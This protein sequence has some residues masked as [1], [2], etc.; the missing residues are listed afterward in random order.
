MSVASK[1]QKTGPI[2]RQKMLWEGPE[3]TGKNG[4]VTQG[5][6]ASFLRCRERARIYCVEGLKRREDFSHRLEFGSMFHAAEEYYSKAV[7]K[8]DYG[9]E[10]SRVRYALTGAT[11]WA[12]GLRNRFP[13]AQEQIE[14]WLQVC[15]VQYPIYKTYW[16]KQQDEVG[17]TPLL[18]E[19]KFS[20]PYK[21]PSGGSVIL[22]GKW[23]GVDLIAGDKEPGIYLYECKTKG[24]VDEVAIKRQLAFDC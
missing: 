21:L 23:D 17:R 7:K 12:R 1:L 22:R 16:A 2:H 13:M 20:V 19:E 5:L 18:Q 10:A 4:G 15:K 8:R 14:H 11:E 24:E 6:I 3:S 9:D